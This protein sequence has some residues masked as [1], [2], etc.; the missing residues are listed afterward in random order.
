MKFFFS[1]RVYYVR[2][3]RLPRVCVRCGIVR[4]IMAVVILQRDRHGK[5]CKDKVTIKVTLG[6]CSHVG[7][8]GLSVPRM[9]HCN[10]LEKIWKFIKDISLHTSKVRRGKIA[11]TPVYHLSR[12][13]MDTHSCPFPFKSDQRGAVARTHHAVSLFHPDPLG[14]WSTSLNSTL[15]AE[16]TENPGL[17]TPCTH[18]GTAS[19]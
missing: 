3:G 11:T 17:L 19:G 8:K 15:F 5:S 12:E 13:S 9:Q 18:L 14:P 10:L 1:A 2:D 16:K 6:F 7:Q 4:R